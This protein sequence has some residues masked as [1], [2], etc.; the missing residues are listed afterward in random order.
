MRAVQCVGFSNSGKTGLVGLL[1]L[2]CERRGFTV[3]IVK[4]S[5]HALALSPSDTTK[6]AA[7]GRTV[8]ALGPEES[9]LWRGEAET[10]QRWAPLLGADLLL[11]EGGKN[12][13]GMPR[14][15]CLRDAAD[16]PQLH[17]H[18]AIATWGPHHVP[19]LPAFAPESIEALADMVLEKA[20]LLPGLDC[21]GC[22]YPGCTALG[23]AIVAGTQQSSACTALANTLSI[24]VDGQELAL[25]AFTAKLIEGALG[26][27]LASL[28]GF[29][30]GRVDICMREKAK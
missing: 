6:L 11:V 1:A 7:P 3:A 9:L 5:H 8:L 26:G 22:G 10:L 24:R 29:K 17:P 27:M 28:K 15:L 4:Y 18:R 30:P 16:A 23:E 14:I 19:G 13:G 21:K 20:F 12:L 25:N 2:A